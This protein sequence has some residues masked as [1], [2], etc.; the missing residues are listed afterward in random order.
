M[1]HRTEKTERLQGVVGHL[2]RPHE[3]VEGIDHLVDGDPGAGIEEV[4][5]KRRSAGAQPLD[6]YL[7]IADHQSLLTVWRHVV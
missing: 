4:A 2:A 1:A 5:H 7:D 6:A 3:V